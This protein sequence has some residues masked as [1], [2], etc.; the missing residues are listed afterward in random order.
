MTPDAP[1]P[2]GP[3]P[4]PAAA[5][6]E[7]DERRTGWSR[8]SGPVAGPI[9]CTEILSGLVPRERDSGYPMIRRR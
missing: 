7:C 2:E 6:R 9:A 5:H 3:G 8:W 4:G 1:A